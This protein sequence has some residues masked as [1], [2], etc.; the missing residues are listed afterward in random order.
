MKYNVDK[1]S[2]VRIIMKARQKQLA[3]KLRREGKTYSEIRKEISVTKSTLSVWL[4]NV[5]LAK[6]Q[7]QR[8]TQKRIDAA[9]RGAR[10]RKLKRIAETLEIY[11]QT[12][13]EVKKISDRELW[14]MG[15]MLY[16]AEGSKQH[17]GVSPSAKLQF[18]NSDQHM[19]ML[20]LKWL[21]KCLSPI[22]SLG[23]VYLKP[24]NPKTIRKRVADTYFG[25][26]RVAVRKSTRLNRMVEG[27]VRGV[28][29]SL[30]I[31]H[32]RG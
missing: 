15:V 25:Q 8:I 13:K 17:E 24:G 6:R 14:L 31:K 28:L 9:Q 2:T 5:G 10:S 21:K 30:Q 16:W 23:R 12:G 1:I 3:I 7:I 29:D 18:S 32:A 11:L 19:I 20:F 4:R 22:T 26:L 27:W